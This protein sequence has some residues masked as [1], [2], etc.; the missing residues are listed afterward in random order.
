MALS[1]FK[2]YPDLESVKGGLLFVV[3]N[4]LV[5]DSYSKKDESTLW[6]KWLS[7]Y[8]RMEQAFENNVWNAHQSGLCKRHCIVTEC[9][10]N[11]R[12]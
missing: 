1:M 10:H 2:L 11:G 6:A 5:K 7:D 12:N 8:S 4:E 3:C 9:V